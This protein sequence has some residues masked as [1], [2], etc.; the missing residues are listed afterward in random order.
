MNFGVLGL[1]ELHNVH[2]KKLWKDKHWITSEDGEIDDDGNNIGK[3]QIPY[4][5][6]VQDTM[7]RISCVAPL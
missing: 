2:N 7:G 3:T 6:Y 4:R 5:I 1:P